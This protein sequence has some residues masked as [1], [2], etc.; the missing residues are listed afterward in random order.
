MRLAIVENIPDLAQQ[1]GQPFYQEQMVHRTEAWPR[2]SVAAI[3]V[4]AAVSLSAVSA[5]FGA[6]WTRDHIVPQVR[7]CSCILRSIARAPRCV[8][9]KA[10]H[11]PS[12]NYTRATTS[13]RWYKPRTYYYILHTEY[14]FASALCS[15]SRWTQASPAGL[16]PSEQDCTCTPIHH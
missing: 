14:V 11:Q 7:N 15:V 1:L 16:Y 2:D 6:D 9:W 3:R 12:A 13:C 10:L 5:Q 8:S 4:A